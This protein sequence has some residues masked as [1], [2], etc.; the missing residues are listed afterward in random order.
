MQKHSDKELA[1]AS[2]RGH[3]KASSRQRILATGAR[4]FRERGLQ[5]ASVNEVMA[6]AG[7]TRGGFYAHFEDK[8]ALV[9]G[10]LHEMFDE[11]ERNWLLH[12]ELRGDAWIELALKRYLSV[13]H[14]QD[15]GRG[16]VMPSLSAELSRGEAQQRQI[17]ATRISGFLRL[18]ENKL[19]EQQGGSSRRERAIALFAGCVGAM[20]IARAVGD[21]ALATEVLRTTRE[22]LRP[23]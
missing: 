7:L 23:R 11:A 13:P 6:G 22:Q 5:G 3:K 19:D 18:V 17:V 1:L 21:P 10:T 9:A 14:L 16:C 4:L 2:Q 12:E 20:T 15:P 8:D